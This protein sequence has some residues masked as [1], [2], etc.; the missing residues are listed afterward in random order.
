MSSFFKVR[1]RAYR[2]DRG[3]PPRL[4]GVGGFVSRARGRALHET[5][6]RA[7]RDRAEDRKARDAGG[8]GGIAD[9][10]GWRTARRPPSPRLGD[11]WRGRIERTHRALLEAPADQNQG[12]AI[13]IPHASEDD[14]GPAGPRFAAPGWRRLARAKSAPSRS[15]PTRAGGFAGPHIGGSRRVGRPARDAPTAAI[16]GVLRRR[17]RGADALRRGGR[18]P[19]RRRIPSGAALPSALHAA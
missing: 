10:R 15:V 4:R 18:R 16:V 14:R 5:S 6:D 12:H 11:G 2:C 9:D 13:G 8:Q 7:V 17:R 1:A 3:V 19:R